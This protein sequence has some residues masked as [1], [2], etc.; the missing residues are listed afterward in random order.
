MGVYSFEAIG[1]DTMVCLPCTAQ[2]HSTVQHN[3]VQLSNGTICATAVRI[4]TQMGMA[5]R[6]QQLVTLC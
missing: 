3:K 5:P 4:A 1:E 2:C 6:Q